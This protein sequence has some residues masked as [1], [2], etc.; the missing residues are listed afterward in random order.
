MFICESVIFI[1]MI[2]R[3]KERRFRVV[4]IFA[5]LF[6]NSISHIGSFVIIWLS[7]FTLF[8]VS[9]LWF[10][11]FSLVIPQ[12]VCVLDDHLY[13]NYAISIFL[14]ALWFPI[15]LFLLSCH[16][17]ILESCLSWLRTFSLNFLLFL[18]Y[19]W[20]IILYWIDFHKKKKGSF[21]ILIHF[22]L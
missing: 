6:S 2:R 17:S 20:F 19:F 13:L 5:S 21:N 7:T 11:V 12:C 15:L 4:W 22:K 18:F 10:F 14:C 8:M 9:A 16:P 1:R 3:W